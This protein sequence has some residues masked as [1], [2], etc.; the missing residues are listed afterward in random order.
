VVNGTTRKQLEPTHIFEKME[1]R[2]YV[3]EGQKKE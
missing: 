1:E 2:K 3:K